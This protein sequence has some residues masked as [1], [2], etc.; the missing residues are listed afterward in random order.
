MQG[1]LNSV[2][3]SRIG[4]LVDTLIVFL[5]LSASYSIVP[6]IVFHQY[7]R[8]INS[9]ILVAIDLIYVYVRFHRAYFVKREPLF[10]IYI[11]LN[12]VNLI[13]AYITDTGW[14]AALAYLVLNSI[15]Y[16]VLY[17]IYM[18]YR[19]WMNVGDTFKFLTRGYLWLIFLALFSSISLFFLSCLGLNLHVNPVNTDYD[20]FKTNFEELG[21]N[22]YFPYNLGVLVDTFDIR[23]PFFQSQGII[24]GL[25]HEAHIV[26]FMTF[27]CLPLM[28]YYMRD[29]RVRFVIT[30]CFALVLLLAGSTT[31][32]IAVLGCLIIYL[33]YRF[34]TSFVKALPLLFVIIIAVTIVIS[35]VDVALFQFI[36]DKMDSSSA[37]YTQTTLEFAVTPKDVIGT[38]I[39]DESEVTSRGNM[40]NRDVGFIVF[41]LNI[42]FLIGCAFNLFK[43]FIAKS[44]MK[45]AYLLFASYFFL[46]STKVAMVAYSLTMLTFIM[47]CISHLSRIQDK[48]LS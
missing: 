24:S 45:L 31:N 30:C 46:H 20:L 13:A 29:S 10:Y 41:F 18:N 33:L 23:I 21:S 28:L 11:F 48:E 40:G 8:F 26:T 6:Y 44:K 37:G 42:L 16:F 27:P 14:Y 36:F 39:Y 19:K 1:K 38:S 34:K 3:P 15:F 9:I 7:H 4:L 35:S 47:F 5:N 12:I 43:L 25:Y 2:G 32:I 22:H 17:N